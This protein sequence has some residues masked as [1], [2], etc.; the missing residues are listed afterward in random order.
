MKT[1]EDFDIAI[2]TLIE[3]RDRYNME[4]NQHIEDRVKF[5]FDNEL[6]LRDLSEFAGKRLESIVAISSIGKETDLP[7][8]ESVDI[9]DN[10]R[11]YCLSYIGGVV[12]FSEEKKTYI[13]NYYSSARELDII[14]FCDIVEDKG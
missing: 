7:L 11:L 3:M 13:H 1:I 2:Q 6:Y 9:L 5:I 4:A 12:A 14:G 8:D 10:G